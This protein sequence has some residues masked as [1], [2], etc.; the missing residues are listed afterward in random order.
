MGFSRLFP[1]PR[2]MRRMPA[3]ALSVAAALCAGGFT[4][5]PAAAHPHIFV[6]TGLKLELDG[7]GRLI[8]V[9][10]T[11]TY[12]ELY[13]LLVLEDMELDDDYD[14]VLRPDEIEKLDGFDLQ[15]DAGFAG[16]L[17]A[18]RAVE[19]GQA[20][21]PSGAET[22]DEAEAETASGAEVETRELAL[23]AP[24]GRGARFKD[25]KITT[26]HFRPLA[27]QRAGGVM[28]RAYDPTYYTAYEISGRIE[29]PAP[30]RG[31]L[32]K[33]DLE[34]AYAEVESRLGGRSASADDYPEVGEFF[35]D[36]VVIS[37]DPA[38]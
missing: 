18:L 24:Q 31:V 20:Q 33:P 6:E 2:A 21:G 1:A 34:R 10:V 37:C 27:A 38:S 28:L 3:A 7:E 23:G 4:A 25:G 14:G 35:A 19:A 5:A 30:C 36:T 22:A 16:D 32:R 26:V 15:W 29:A 9:E 11:W 13:S 17:Y 8:G 12:D